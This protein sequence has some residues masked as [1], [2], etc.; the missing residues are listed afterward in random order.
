MK[1]RMLFREN[2]TIIHTRSSL[3]DR[4]RPVVLTALVTAIVLVLPALIDPVEL[5]EAP[6]VVAL[7]DHLAELEA[8]ELQLRQVQQ[9]MGDRLAQAYQRGV[10]DGRGDMARVCRRAQL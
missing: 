8:H 2:G 5:D 10:Q 4:L 9:E 3:L 1:T 6:P 7:A